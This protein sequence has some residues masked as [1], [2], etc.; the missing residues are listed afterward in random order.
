[1]GESAESMADSAQ[2]WNGTCFLRERGC[3]AA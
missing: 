3:R 1:M 2:K